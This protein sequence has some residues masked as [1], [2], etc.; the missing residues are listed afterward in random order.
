MSSTGK[1]GLA[2]VDTG[3]AVWMLLQRDEGIALLQRRMLRK[4]DGSEGGGKRL[5]LEYESRPQYFWLCFISN[6]LR[7][8][9]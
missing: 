1:E 8:E 9:K 7:H 5:A 3:M 6:S 2:R 4:H